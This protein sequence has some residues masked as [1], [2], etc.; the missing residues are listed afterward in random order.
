MLLVICALLVILLS[1]CYDMREVSEELYAI[2][3]AVDKNVDG[4]QVSVA[5][6]VYGG[7]EETE[8]AVF[9]SEGESITE[10]LDGLNL[11]LSRKISLLHLKAVVFSEGLA[12]DGLLEIAGAI[13]KHMETT[14]AMGVMI[15]EG[16]GE[17][18]LT[19]L[20]E[21]ASGDLSKETEL[22]LLKGRQGTFYPVVRFENFYNDMVS[23]YRSPCSAYADS[24]GNICGIAVFSGEKM[25][26]D[27]DE[28]ESVC[29]M[30]I[31]MRVSEKNINFGE[32]TVLI[33]KTD[34]S[35]DWNDVPVLTLKIRGETEDN[36]AEL[37]ER[38][39]NT[40]EFEAESV[41]QKCA[42]HGADPAGLK[43]KLAKDFF[44]IDSWHNKTIDLINTV[45]KVELSLKES[46]AG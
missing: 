43:G 7:G 8:T 24:E 14:S 31:R 35:A 2:L 26:L 41:I 27:L 29:L 36:D 20:C 39:K 10:C 38:I 46:E 16:R 5:V 22:M 4:L 1:G 19:K 18:Y 9:K 21:E 42:R 15:T 32:N 45:V 12:S 25:M 40:L 6:P 33:R 23:P 28:R 30:M 44:T 34:S 3:L 13:Q 11:T 17:D 37:Y